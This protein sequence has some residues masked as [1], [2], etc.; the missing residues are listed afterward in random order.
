M[1]RKPKEAGDFVDA[2]CTRCKILKIHTIVAM[3]AGKVVRVKCNSC[4]GEHN[5]HAPIEAKEPR[6]CR[7]TITKVGRPSQSCLKQV[8]AACYQEQWTAALARLEGTTAVAYKLDGRYIKNML[9]AH[10]TF[11]MGVVIALSYGKM[12]V[13]FNDGPTWLG[14]GQ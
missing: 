8:S 12:E 10:P 3:V 6:T 14:C 13:F 2:K 11:G 9:I 7:P 5:Y 1:K 4:G